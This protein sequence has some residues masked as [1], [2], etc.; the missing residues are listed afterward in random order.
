MGG[1]DGRCE[2]K[3]ED[4]R[5][6]RKMGKEKKCIKTGGKALKMHLY[7]FA[8]PPSANLFVGKKINLKRGGRMIKMHNIYPWIFYLG[9]GP[10]LIFSETELYV[11]ITYTPRGCNSGHVRR[12]KLFFCER[13]KVK[14]IQPDVECNFESR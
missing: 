11:C 4:L 7:G 6:K 5:G 10:D 3:N 9:M 14:K 1:G 12:I 13:N 2:K 8:P